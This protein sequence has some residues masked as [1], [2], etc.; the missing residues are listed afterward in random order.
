MLISPEWVE[1]EKKSRIWLWGLAF[2]TLSSLSLSL[3]I[4]VFLNREINER[5]RMEEKLAAHQEGLRSCVSELSLAE[6]RERRRIAVHLHDQVG[7]TL[8]LANIKLGELQKFQL[9]D[10]T[11]C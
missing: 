1:E 2:G 9:N 4:M 5:K 11:A 7:Q 10:P 3:L 6:E 8:A